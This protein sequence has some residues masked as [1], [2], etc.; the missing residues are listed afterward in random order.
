MFVG[1]K[2]AWRSARVG[3]AGNRANQPDWGVELGGRQ[4]SMAESLRSVPG[5]FVRCAI[6]VLQPVAADECR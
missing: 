5:T 1:G 3:G 4:D 2:E 6:I